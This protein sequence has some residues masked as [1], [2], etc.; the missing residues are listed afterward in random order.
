MH[1]NYPYLV[2]SL[3]RNSEFSIA[4][5][6]ELSIFRLRLYSLGSW[7]MKNIPALRYIDRKS[8]V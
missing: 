3:V 8:V 2:R 4:S 7:S 1:L 6:E 5:T